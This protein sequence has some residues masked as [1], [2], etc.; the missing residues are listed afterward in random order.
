LKIFARYTPLLLL[1]FVLCANV[2]NAF[3]QGAV[4]KTANEKANAPVKQINQASKSVSDSLADKTK[5]ANEEVKKG[6]DKINAAADSLTQAIAKP[7]SKAAKK[8]DDKVDEL[9]K[10][11][12]A[13]ADKVKK[14]TIQKNTWPVRTYH[15]IT[16]Y[17]NV[18]FNA[19]DAYKE[20]V[21]EAVKDYPYDF[22]GILPVFL[23]VDESV[24]GKVTANMQRA[25]EKSNK[26]IKVHS[27]TNKPAIKKGKRLTKK[28]QDFYNKRE[29]CIW[30]D[31][32]YFTIGMSNVYLHEYELAL[33]AFDHIAVEY[34]TE[35]IAYEA[36]IWSAIVEGEMGNV[37]REEEVLSA[38]AGDKKFPK[39]YKVLRG[40]ART[41]LFIRKKNYVE[42]IPTLEQVMED[43]WFNRST[44]RRYHYILAQMYQQMGNNKKAVEHYTSVIR[45]NPSTDM[46]FNA[47]LNRA[48]LSGGRVET[49]RSML[50]KMAK[51]EKNKDYL[52]KIYF[53]LA[54]VEMRAKRPDEA[55]KYYRL[56]AMYAKRDSPQRLKSCYTLAKYYEGKLDYE[57]AQ[58]YYDSTA[59]VMPRTDPDYT[60]VYNKAKNL[61]L[62][63]V[64]LRIIRTEDSLQR[65]AK[66]APKERDRYVSAQITKAKNLQAQKKREEAQ[67]AAQMALAAKS[68]ANVAGGKWYFYNPSMM[69]AGATEFRKTWGDRALADSWRTSASMEVNM[70]ITPDDEKGA[71]QTLVADENQTPEDQTPEYYLANVPLT[72][73]LMDSSNLRVGNA[74]FEAARVYKDYLLDNPRAIEMLEALL[75]R[76]PGTKNRMVAYFYLYTLYHQ[77]KD[78]AKSVKY[79]DKLIAEFPDEPLTHYVKDP[80]YVSSKELEQKA[81]EALYEKAYNEYR[82]GKYAQAIQS[83]EQGLQKYSSMGIASN[84]MLI[85]AMAKGSDKNVGAYTSNLQSVISQYP[86]T[87]AAEAAQ[88]IMSVVR[89]HEASLLQERE[90]Q[91]VEVVSTEKPSVEY[92][93]EDGP[94]YFVV[95][96]NRQ[97]TNINQLRFNIISFNADMDADDLN[98]EVRNLSDELTML[99]VSP[100]ANQV[101]AL[102]YFRIIST[103]KLI[104]KDLT[105]PVFSG[106]TI[107][108]DNLELFEQD[109]IISTY[110]DFF[111]ENVNK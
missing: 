12:G 31:N 5:K 15:N 40:Q 77:E 45:R 101:A 39:K 64:N 95:I 100:F 35:P 37:D 22:T 65:I 49:M 18:Y 20:G 16:G 25:L 109:K 66:M 44:K 33:K 29:Y 61:N 14:A 110:V 59:M 26:T 46:E 27:I 83:A 69:A 81:A 10:R 63:A 13:V 41:D 58:L 28:E 74:M 94:S 17:Y 1:T 80:S 24:P 54:E 3:A 53:A 82:T 30:V 11:A 99:V 108:E 6:T 4:T 60:T 52:D 68:G 104:I 76:Y 67:L 23:F 90:Q 84:F 8:V 86:G 21:A 56:S 34:P 42:A 51:E 70:G 71:K 32:A 7:V 73:E 43:G 106:F 75:K 57:N 36:R 93:T 103:N 92:K 2:G 38:I 19:K 47:K 72:P 105:L 9:N 102:K 107:T 79:K 111:K 91:E 88:Q 85:R 97:A 78:E 87:Q 55:E 62:L 96:V 50:L 89:K 98:V 48:A